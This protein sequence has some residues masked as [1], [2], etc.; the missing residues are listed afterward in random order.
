MSAPLLLLALLGHAFLWV[1]FVNRIHGRAWPE[2]FLRG[3]M[4]ACGVAFLLIPPAYAL[5]VLPE[6][7]LSLSTWAS[8]AHAIRAGLP[9]LAV[10]WTAAAVHLSAWTWRHV[11]HRPTE[12]LLH[13]SVRPAELGAGGQ[14]ETVPFSPPEPPHHPLVY[15]PLNEI[16]DVAVAER[17]LE[18]EHLPAALD[19]LSIVHLSDVHFTGRVA[20]SWFRQVA[21]CCNR[22]RPD[23]VA[24]TGDVIDNMACLDWLPDTL[25]RLSAPGGV[26]FILGNHD[27]RRDWPRIRAAM[28]AC[29]M[30]S[31]SGRWLES[32][33]RAARQRILLAGNELPWIVPA[34]DMRSAPPPAREGGP[35]RILLSHSPDQLPWARH[36][37][38]DL[39]LAGHTHG[40]QIR[41]PLIGAVLTPS[42]VGVRYASG[43]FH[44][45]P[46]VMH[47][48]RGVSAE[49]PVRW[50][51]RPEI[52]LLVLR[53]PVG[54]SQPRW[55]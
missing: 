6:G 19:G 51:C 12:A 40:G 27:W 7:G 3:L 52:A 44:E 21:E 22:L 5:W 33:F 46:T 53:A 30:I 16:L 18:I 54:K 29:G 20:R 55:G 47:V 8:P 26:Y 25:G 45:P 10:C 38:F 24:L 2:W 35:L 23:L 11:L 4:A 41:F 50:N 28:C 1:G 34:A 43:V 31:L 14:M 13:E 17:H 36:H 32:P 15:L 49:L 39:M 42:R 37:Q 9:Y 48:T